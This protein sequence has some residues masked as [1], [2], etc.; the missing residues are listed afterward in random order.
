MVCR[1]AIEAP[2][3]HDTPTAQTL[4]GTSLVPVLEFQLK[5]S[6]SHLPSF[7]YPSSGIGATALYLR[8][9][10]RL[11]SNSSL[12]TQRTSDAA[13]AARKTE[14]RMLHT[15]NLSHG[16]RESCS[17]CK[18]FMGSWIEAL[19]RT[20]CVQ[21]MLGD[22]VGIR[23]GYSGFVESLQG[24]LTTLVQCL[25]Q[26]HVKASGSSTQQCSEIHYIAGAHI[27]LGPFVW[28]PDFELPM[29]P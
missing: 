29:H 14:T 26:R 21:G 19:M 11:L 22:Y 15:Q 13:K 10:I 3:V 18:G 27:Q 9:R 28:A 1:C 8:E 20:A 25:C 17:K 2:V 16:F 24:K 4:L 12:T 6:D 23:N 7:V 5:A